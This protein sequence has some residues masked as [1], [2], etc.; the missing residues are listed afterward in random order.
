[1]SSDETAA[2]GEDA[3]PVELTLGE[4]LRSVQA[5]ILFANEAITS[6]QERHLAYFFTTEHGVTRARTVA[7]PMPGPD[8]KAIVRD[9]PLFALVPHN[10]MAMD[11]LRIEMHVAIDRAG[12]TG[13]DRL[14]VRLGAVPRD[15]PPPLARIEI[16]FK[17]AEMPEGVARLYNE[18]VKFI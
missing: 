14:A 12:C 5:S 16:T 8:G 10:Q 18:I 11:R 3:Y 6:A 7:V 1:M 15:E 4:L 17:R 13:S 9:V 2:Q